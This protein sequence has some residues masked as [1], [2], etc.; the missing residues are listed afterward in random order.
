MKKI[1]CA[2]TVP[3]LLISLLFGKENKLPVAKKICAIT[4]TT[5][6]IFYA[7]G[8]GY[9]FDILIGEKILIHQPFIPA[10]QGNKSFASKSDAT[11][12]ARLMLVKLKQHE[13]PPTISIAE[14]DSLHIHH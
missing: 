9:G 13:M 12:T 8:L 10:A 6:R 4:D 1:I 14:L 3:L 7:Q 2:F 5:F 11:K